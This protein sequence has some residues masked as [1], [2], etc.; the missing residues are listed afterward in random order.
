MLQL[1]LATFS[2]PMLSENP[3]PGPFP[4]GMG[5]GSVDCTITIGVKYTKAAIA[6]CH[7]TSAT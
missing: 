3:Y 5:Y 4:E 2:Q 6:A 1:F 7:L